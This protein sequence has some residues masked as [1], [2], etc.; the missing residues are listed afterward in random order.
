MD[1]RLLLLMNVIVFIPLTQGK[2]AVIDFEDFEKVRGMKWYAAKNARIWYAWHSFGHRGPRVSLHRFILNPPSDKEVS[3]QDGDGLN[4]TRSN[5]QICSHAQNMCF[6]K[7]KQIGATSQF[8]GV[9]LEKGK[10]SPWRASFFMNGKSF[11]LGNFVQEKDAAA[12]WDKKAREVHGEMSF[13][14]F[15]GVEVACAS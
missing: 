11:R 15:P 13:Q 12:A 10:A 8:R 3:H 5:I 14:N 7:K 9:S 2:V 4:N 6:F 1:A